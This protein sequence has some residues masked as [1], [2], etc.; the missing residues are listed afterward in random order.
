MSSLLEVSFIKEKTME[1][2]TNNEQYLEL[3]EA[4]LQDVTGGEF[5]PVKSRR[6]FRSGTP[7]TLF[8]HHMSAALA[9]SDQGDTKSVLWHTKQAS[10]QN[11]KISRG[12]K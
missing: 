6:T 7:Q 9:A 1:E 4:Q 12:P 8:E 11:N 10:L 2:N 3:D 5:D